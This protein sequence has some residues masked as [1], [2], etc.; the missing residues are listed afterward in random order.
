MYTIKL[1]ARYYWECRNGS[2]HYLY[3][4]LPW[5]HCTSC[6][7]FQLLGIVLWSF[8]FAFQKYLMQMRALGHSRQ[9]DVQFSVIS[10]SNYVSVVWGLVLKCYRK[11]QALYAI[12]WHPFMIWW[13]TRR[14]FRDALL[15]PGWQKEQSCFLFI[16]SSWNLFIQVWVLY[17]LKLGV[18]VSYSPFLPA[19]E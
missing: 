11:M 7:W 14:W 17:H 9:G 6:G 13:W 3:L 10:S 1:V 16:Y 8:E 18:G 2:L 19:P 12:R 5:K 15:R 4:P